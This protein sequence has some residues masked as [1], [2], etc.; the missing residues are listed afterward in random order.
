MSILASAGKAKLYPTDGSG[1]DT[2]VAINNGGFSIMEK[3]SPGVKTR[4]GKVPARGSGSF[5]SPQARPIHYQVNGTGRDSY[6]HANDGGLATN[7]G[8]YNNEEAY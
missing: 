4:F 3:Q 5:G 8:K 7:F 1:R 2:Y 6:I